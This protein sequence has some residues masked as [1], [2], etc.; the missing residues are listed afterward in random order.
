[1]MPL[2]GF[3]VALSV[4]MGLVAVLFLWLLVS[5]WLDADPAARETQ[6][7]A[8]IACAGAALALTVLAVLEM[9]RL[10]G[11]PL[12]GVALDFAAL[13]A[14]Y[15]AIIVELRPASEPRESD[16]VVTARFHAIGA[17]RETILGREKFR[18]QRPIDD[19]KRHHDDDERECGVDGM[20][21]EQKVQRTQHTEHREDDK[22]RELHRSG[23]SFVLLQEAVLRLFAGIRSC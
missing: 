22:K 17:A 19:G 6:E 4:G 16:M 13:L 14:S 15:V 2:R 18:A 12:S 20:S 10:G 21:L 3:H 7:V 5:A 1:M 8:R 11:P 23:K 9:L